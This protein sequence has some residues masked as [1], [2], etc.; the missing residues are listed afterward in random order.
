MLLFLAQSAW[1]RRS[2]GPNP[3]YSMGYWQEFAKT[4]VI[5]YLLDHPDHRRRRICG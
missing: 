2:L 1:S 4:I 3:A 5:S